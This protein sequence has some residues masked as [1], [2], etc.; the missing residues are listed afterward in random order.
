MTRSRDRDG[1]APSPRFNAARISDRSVDELIGICRGV[2]ADGIVSAGEPEFLLAWLE[3]NKEAANQWPGNMLYA[4]IVEMF[5][6]GRIDEDEESELLDILHD[7]TGRGI[8]LP[9][10]ARSYSTALPLC[11]PVPDIRADGRAFVLT[12]KF[13]TGPRKKCET[14]LRGM[15]GTSKS[16]P[17]QAVDYLVIGAIGSGEWIHSTHGRKIEK[18]VELRAKGARIS[19]VSEQDWAERLGIA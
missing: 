14:L 1:M 3:S 12:G 15:G 4:R 16:T 13:A 19:I 7:L 18:A 5:E 17:S 2:L 6:D 11:K 10:Q 8:P 9:E